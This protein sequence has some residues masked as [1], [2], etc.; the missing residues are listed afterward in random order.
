[1]DSYNSLSL[2]LGADRRTIQNRLQHGCDKMENTE[3]HLYQ[4][5]M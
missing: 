3:I 4:M 1:M 5:I 2:N